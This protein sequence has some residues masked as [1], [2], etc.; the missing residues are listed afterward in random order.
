MPCRRGLLHAVEDDA[1]SVAAFLAGDDG[2]A[3]A[4]APD[5]QLLDRGGAEG[6]AGREQD[7][8]ICF[9]Q[10][11]AE[12]ADGRRLARAVDADDQDHVRTRK[13]PYLQGLGDRAL[14]SS[15][16][17][18]Q[19]SCE[20]R[21]RRVARSG[22][23]RS[24]RGYGA[25]LRGRGRTRSALPRY[26]QASRC[27]AR[28]CW[29]G[30]SNCPQPGP[31]SWRSR[32]AGDRASSCP[33]AR[34]AGAVAGRLM[35]AEPAVPRPA[36]DRNRR[37]IVGVTDPIAFDHHGL[38]RAD[39]AFQPARR[40]ARPLQREA[41]QR[42]PSRSRVSTCGM[43][44]AG[45]SGRGEKGK[46]CAATMSQSSSNFSVF[47][48][49]SSVSV[50]NPAMRS[51]PI[52]ASARAALIRST[53]RTASRT[54]MPPLHPLQDHVVAGLERQVEM[55]HQPRLAGDQ[56]EQSVIDLDAVE[57][58]QAQALEPRL[59]SK[60]PLAKQTRPPS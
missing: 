58:R 59:G 41:V 37:E 38:C 50:G 12:L 47:S 43:R 20:G 33:N 35:R 8:V 17:L 23:Q 7:A 11:L 57:R 28:P 2:R 22:A 18:R 34:Q 48:A 16:S 44:A 10:P 13:A 19:G 30:R 45:V 42:G 9:L 32:R 52:V 56:L 5:R 55:R 27:R 49:I 26:R 31:R 6:I 24:R 14:K 3:D 36:F 53:V 29:S 51:A 25:M 39:Q 1:G 40:A 46:M 21:A 54:A 60:Q 4:L 15:R